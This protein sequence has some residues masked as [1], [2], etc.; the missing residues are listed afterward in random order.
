M[1]YTHLS[2]G[3]ANARIRQLES[4]LGIA[5]SES[6]FNVKD[7][8]ARIAELE[9]QFVAKGKAVPPAQPKG[10][11]L[12]GTQKAVTEFSQP[13]PDD[14]AM[15]MAGQERQIAQLTNKITEMSAQIE[16]TKPQKDVTRLTAAFL[17]VEGQSGARRVAGLPTDEFILSM[18][19]TLFYSGLTVEGHDLSHVGS[20][21][22]GA[23]K[24]QVGLARTMAAIK[25]EKIDE[26]LSKLK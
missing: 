13:R 25:Q 16:A 20:C 17:A 9:G 18:E 2:A 23:A 8:N 15:K 26:T 21:S 3:S 6:I 1:I 7:F 22:Y 24:P 11:Q 12:A 19:K 10:K 14:F 5:P 4:G